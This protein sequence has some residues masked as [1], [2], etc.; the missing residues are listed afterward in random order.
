VCQ[1]YDELIAKGKSVRKLPLLPQ[2]AEDDVPVCVL[3]PLT[4]AG[5]SFEVRIRFLS[6]MNT[7]SGD[8]R[9]LGSAFLSVLEFD[10][11]STIASSAEQQ[12]LESV[13][14][15]RLPVPFDGPTFKRQERSSSRILPQEKA[16]P[17]RR[18]PTGTGD[19]PERSPAAIRKRWHCRNAVVNQN[20]GV[21]LIVPC[22]VK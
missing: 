19:K 6:M 14:R 1:T 11:N 4:D 15:E 21:T 22:E 12:T 13:G 8:D 5:Q 3:R 17:D 9:L 20:S 16:R 2:L 7:H 18:S 10:L